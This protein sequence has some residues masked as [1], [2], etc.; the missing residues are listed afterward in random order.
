MEEVV[1]PKVSEVG[2]PASAAAEDG[3]VLVC[4]GGGGLGAAAVNAEVVRHGRRGVGASQ[5]GVLCAVKIWA[6][7][8]G[9]GRES[10]VCYWYC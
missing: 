8:G 10:V 6:D 2:G 1:Q 3:T 9:T 7:C 5:A 4:D